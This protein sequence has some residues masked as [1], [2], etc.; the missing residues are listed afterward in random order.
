MSV[1]AVLLDDQPAWKAAPADGAASLLTA[2]MGAHTYVQYLCQS[3]QAVQAMQIHVVP[4]DELAADEQAALTAEAPVTI[5]QREAL[6]QL[7]DTLESSD[8]LLIVNARKYP[9]NGYLFNRLFENNGGGQAT[10]HLVHLRRSSLDAEERILVDP[11]GSLRAIERVYSGVTQLR[12]DGVTASLVSVA[13]L[14][15]IQLGRQWSLSDIRVKLAS[16]H[17]MSNDVAMTT[18]VLDLS[19]PRDW[20]AAVEHQVVRETDGVPPSG[21]KEIRPGVWAADDVCIDAS[22]KICG[23]AILHRGAHIEEGATLVGPVL[24]GQ[25]VRVARGAVVAHSFV[26]SGA[27]I[28]AGTQQIN[29]VITPEHQVSATAADFAANQ[30]GEDGLGEHTLLELDFAASED[31]P[32]S[33]SGESLTDQIKRGLDV[34]AA[35]VGLLFLLLPLSLVALLVKLTSRGPVFFGHDREGRDGRPFR[36]WKFRTM[37][38][39]AHLAQRELYAK[40]AVDG[41]QF[42]LDRDPRVTTLGRILRKTNIDELPQ[43]WNVLRGEM[44]LIGP[45]PSPF[46]ENQICVPWRKARLSVR[47]GITGLWQ[48]CRHDRDMGDFHQWIHFDTLYVR[49]QS[50]WLDMKILL[51][52][53][54]T[55]GGRWSVPASWLLSEPVISGT[56]EASSLPGSGETRVAEKPVAVAEALPLETKLT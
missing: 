16:A 45:R 50:L 7:L 6:P 42:K 37:V 2:Q 35:A 22:A 5:T 23:S 11:D 47:P 33:D 8:L 27:T 43:L 13:A 30:P 41:P 44:S 29:Q 38:E 34:T 40:N 49:H 25:D 9:V 19:T 36:C 24:L 12:T 17:I 32:T 4:A 54:F 15:S 20:L 52:T 28:L 26:A 55:M 18:A 53:L 39:N 10:R 56:S 14:R 3:V 1:I 21:L 51:A 46:R 48:I 31:V